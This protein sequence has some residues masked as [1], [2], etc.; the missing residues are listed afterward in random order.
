MSS[1]CY[2]PYI[3]DSERQIDIELMR[4]IKRLPNKLSLALVKHYVF[5]SKNKV[6]FD[7]IINKD[8]ISI[9]YKDHT[10]FFPNPIPI[11][12]LF[13]IAYG[14]QKWLYRKYILPEFIEINEGDIV[15][16]CGGFVGGF[17]MLSSYVAE[18]IYIFEPDKTNFRCLQMNFKNQDNVILINAGLYNK[19][20]KINFNISDSA[21]EHSILEPDDGK[22]K[23]SIEIQV[24]KLSDFV[25]EHS[26]NKID[27]CKIEAEGVEPEIL[28]GALDLNIPKL[29]IDCSPERKGLSPFDEITSTLTKYGYE[30]KRHGWVLLAK[31]L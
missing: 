26:I 18:K 14:Y 1:E 5:L 29:A 15:V 3:P 23:E 30:T 21:V 17:S 22:I 24:Y 31:K 2:F 28:Q 20:M 6:K 12:D 11:W 19:T 8:S 27:F 4:F 9:I 7:Y 25:K 16:D 13:F 10:I